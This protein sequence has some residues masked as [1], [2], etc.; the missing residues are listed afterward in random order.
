MMVGISLRGAGNITLTTDFGT[1]QGSD[2]VMHGAIYR[3]APTLSSRTVH[4]T[5]LHLDYARM[6][7]LWHSVRVPPAVIIT[8]CLPSISS[9]RLMAKRSATQ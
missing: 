6:T 4:T 7:V 8:S 2:A 5:Y 1:R 9:P 3:I